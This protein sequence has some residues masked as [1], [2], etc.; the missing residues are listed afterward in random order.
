MAD[1]FTP[2]KRSAI[3]SRIKG[4]NTK[5]EI[6]VR[7]IVHSLGFRFRLRPQNL[8]GKPDLVLPRYRKIIF[9]HG[10]FW[11]GHAR[12]RRSTLPTSNVAFWQKKIEGNKARDRNVVRTLR[13]MK[14]DILVVWQCETTHIE[15]LTKRL[16]RFL[17]GA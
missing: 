12:C 6:L 16:E 4:G 5:P 8:V 14:W 11:H 7:R 15:R 10:C 13:R 17:E 9:V 3:M 2:E 1:V